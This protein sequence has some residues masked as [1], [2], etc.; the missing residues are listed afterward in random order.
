MLSHGELPLSPPP[1]SYVVYSSAD[2]D[3][4]IELDCVSFFY[5]KF[6]HGATSNTTCADGFVSQ[7]LAS[8]GNIDGFVSMLVRV[9][10]RSRYSAVYY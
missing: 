1:P 2:R 9:S 3:G 10:A 8:S 6:T 4:R 5:E 7:G